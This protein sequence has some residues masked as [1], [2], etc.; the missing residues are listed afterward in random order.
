MEAFILS[1][2]TT[3]NLVVRLGS[4][5]FFC[6]FGVELLMQIGLMKYLKPI[7]KPFA[8]IANLPSES[9]VSFLAGI[10]SMIAAHTIA[11][12]FHTDNKLTN[13]EL[14]LTGVLNTVPFHFKEILTFQ[15]PIVLPLLGL[16]L[17]LIYI[18]AFLLTGFLK[19]TFVLVLGNMTTSKSVQNDDVFVSYDCDP[20]DPECIPRT[21]YKIVKETINARKKMF[22]RMI[23][24]LAIVSLLIQALINTGMLKWL[25]KLILPVTN[26]FELPA[27]VVGPVSA[28]VFSPTVGITYMSNLLSQ[29]LISPYQAIVSLFAGSLL[30]IPVSRLRRT[31]PRYTSIFGLK[32]GTI[33]CGITTA[34]SMTSRILILIW[35][36]LFF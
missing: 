3:L 14:I 29:N 8:K 30:M 16:K 35:V 4:V 17:C 34:L 33:I 2:E 11:A 10:G 1:V 6:L 12:G 32:N 9:A 23:T 25:E 24:T 7:G 20:E 15:L 19:L 21:M 28:Y 18:A 26:L 13:R 36:I 22:I 27:S 31:L 5:M